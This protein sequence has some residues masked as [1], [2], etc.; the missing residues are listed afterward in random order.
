MRAALPTKNA[1][2]TAVHRQ[3]AAVAAA[4]D[5]EVV[6]LEDPSDELLWQGRADCVVFQSE[7]LQSTGSEVNVVTAKRMIVPAMC[8]LQI[9]DRL[10]VQQHGIADKTYR[11]TGLFLD[12]SEFHGTS[13]YALVVQEVK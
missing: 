4:D 5:W 2:V 10:T 3:Q 1:S 8:D 6:A 9:D 11:V 7:V 12:T 13:V